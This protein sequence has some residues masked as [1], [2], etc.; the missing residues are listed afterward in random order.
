VGTTEVKESLPDSRVRHSLWGRV[1][2]LLLDPLALEPGAGYYVD[3]WGARAWSLEV[4]LYWEAAP[5][6]LILRPSVRF[7][8]QEAVKYFVEGNPAAV[9]EYHTQDS[10]LGEFTTLVYGL[11]LTSLKSPL[12]GDELEVGLDIASRSDGISWF[13]ISV[14]F[15]WK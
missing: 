5:R 2:H 10:D 9:P 7:H 1:R 8:S 4:G 6:S 12:P 13:T 14:N 3:D 15:A 11:K